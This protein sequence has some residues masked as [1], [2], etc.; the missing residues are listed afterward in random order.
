MLFLI[1]RQSAEKLLQCPVAC[2]IC[3]SSV[4]PSCGLFGGYGNANDTFDGLINPR[5]RRIGADPKGCD[6]Q[7][8]TNDGGAAQATNGLTQ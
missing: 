4:F 6:A 2:L 5:A 7:I 8:R 3:K 1:C